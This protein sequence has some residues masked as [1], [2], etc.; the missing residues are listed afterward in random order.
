MVPTEL[1]GGH[2]MDNAALENPEASER[3]EN[4]RRQG[5]RRSPST[6]TFEV[7]HHIFRQGESGQEAFIVKSGR[8]EIYS[9]EMEGGVGREISLAILNE[10]EMFGEMA[11]I[12][13]KPRMASARPL[14]APASVYVVSQRKF[15][16]M[17]EPVNP[18]VIKLLNILVGHVRGNYDP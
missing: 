17:L 6:K 18:F 16:L 7:N 4:P 13:D 5:E 15:N 12:D 1:T 8:V 14:G 10:G 3:R 9:V 2:P 11:L